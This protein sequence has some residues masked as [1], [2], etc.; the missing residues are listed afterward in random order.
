MGAN[1]N[2]EEE[3]EREREDLALRLEA[4]LELPMLVLAV[5]WLA[6]LV[7]EFVWTLT[8]FLDALFY[9]VWIAF[10]LEYAVRFVLAPHKGAFV[11]RTW[12]TLLSLPIPVLRFLV[13]AQAIRLVSVARGVRLAR[14]VTSANRGMKTLALN[15]GRRRLA[16]VLGTTAVVML[17][18][19]AGMYAFERV[20]E[21]GGLRDFGHALWWTAM[22]MTTIGTD[23]WPV[24]GAGRLLSL[25]LSIYAIGVFGYITATLATFFIELD[26]GSEAGELASGKRLEALRQEIAALRE[27]LRRSRDR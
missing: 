4:A 20:D 3:V 17:T 19:A 21:G 10:I 14:V 24:T 8:P 5:V 11:R 27:E 22:I 26:A 15:L 1:R 13:A 9:A 16:Y 6:L 2:P 7:V 25:L 23:Y 18:G 12:L